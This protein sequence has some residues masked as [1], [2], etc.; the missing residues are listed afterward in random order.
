MVTHQEKVWKNEKLKSKEIGSF[1]EYVYKAMEH[2][3]N[4]FFIS[5]IQSKVANRYL[6]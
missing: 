1:H 3:E 4:M 2:W 6:K 5:I